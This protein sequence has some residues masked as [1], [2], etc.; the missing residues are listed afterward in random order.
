MNIYIYIYIYIHTYRHIHIHI[1]IYIYMNIYIYI[2]YNI[3]L[4]SKGECEG[5]RPSWTSVGGL[6]GGR[7]PQE[8]RWGV[9]WGGKANF[10]R[11]FKFSHGGKLVSYR[12]LSYAVPYF[13]RP[14]NSKPS[15]SEIT[16]SAT[17]TE[18]FFTRWIMMRM[19][20]MDIRL[21]VMC[22]GYSFVGWGFWFWV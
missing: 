9:W 14:W 2:L 1:Y 6:E 3:I 17:V 21:S 19:W 5:Q 22:C 11:K 10:R 20:V 13:H 4:Y 7:S 8:C 18:A 16:F 15:I 12:T